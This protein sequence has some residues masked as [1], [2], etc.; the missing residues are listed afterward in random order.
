MWQKH[1]RKY[2][3]I[4][5]AVFITYYAFWIVLVEWTATPTN[6]LTNRLGDKELA[7]AIVTAVLNTVFAAKEVVESDFCRR[8]EYFRSFWNLI[9][10]GSLMLVYAYIV[11]ILDRDIDTTSQSSAIPLAAVTTLVLTTKLLA[12]L[13]G[14]SDTGWL[15]TVLIQNF[16]DVKGFLLILLVILI[17]F[18]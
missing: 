18:T 16:I 9:D 15:I 14:F 12:Y 10:V 3:F 2:F 7:F 11:Y 1:V 5:V 6:S 4:D 8:G 13:R 17:G